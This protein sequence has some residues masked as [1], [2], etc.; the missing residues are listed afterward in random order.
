MWSCAYDYHD[1]TRDNGDETM[2]D[3]VFLKLGG[4]LTAEVTDAGRLVERH[5]RT[6]GSRSLRLSAKLATVAVSSANSSDVP[7]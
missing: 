3:L 5:D 1:H 2:K 7:N 6:A 4:S